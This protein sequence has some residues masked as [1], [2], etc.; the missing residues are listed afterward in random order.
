MQINTLFNLLLA[1][2]HPAVRVGVVAS[3][4]GVR[5][6]WQRRRRTGLLLSRPVTHTHTQARHTHVHT[7][8]LTPHNQFLQVYSYT[9][10][11]TLER[12]IDVAYRE[13]QN[14]ACMSLRRNFI[15]ISSVMNHD[16]RT[17]IYHKN[18]YI[19]YEPKL[20]RS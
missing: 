5:A 7:H 15:R 16:L 13:S 2:Y 12:D 14:P 3:S 17:S 6:G 4:H 1:S 9:T 10:A 11:L 19:S 8:T 20:T 18:P